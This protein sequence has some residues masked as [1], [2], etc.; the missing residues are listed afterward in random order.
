[1]LCKVP[2]LHRVCFIQSIPGLI[3]SAQSRKTIIISCWLGC[4]FLVEIMRQFL[5]EV[6]NYGTGR[7]RTSSKTVSLFSSSVT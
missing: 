4:G 2:P 1:M 3:G 7:I 6:D 5:T